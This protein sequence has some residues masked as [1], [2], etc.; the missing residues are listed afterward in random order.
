MKKIISSVLAACI[1]AGMPSAVRIHAEDNTEKAGSV[2]KNE[3]V[4]IITDA[5]G[6]TDDVI[7]SEG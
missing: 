3:T 6:N 5:S 1:I 7:V 2:E 4:Y